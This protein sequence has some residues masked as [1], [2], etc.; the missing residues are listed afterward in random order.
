MRRTVYYRF[1]VSNSHTYR[2]YVP[3]LGT[4]SIPNSILRRMEHRVAPRAHAARGHLRTR[5][6]YT[7]L[8]SRPT[9]QEQPTET[10][11]LSR[12]VD[13]SPHTRL[14]GRD[15]RVRA[16]SWTRCHG[17]RMPMIGQGK[18]P[19]GDRAAVTGQA[20]RRGSTTV[21]RSRTAADSGNRDAD[22]DAHACALSK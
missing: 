6:V 17:T 20:S 11:P 5:R 3:T 10:D 4:L 9:A 2:F 14:E 8:Q 16:S 22:G 7:T 12:R 13:S 21:H 18:H 15:K 1:S 19:H